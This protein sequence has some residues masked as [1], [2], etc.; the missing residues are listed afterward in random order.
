MSRCPRR[1]GPR[2]LS[3]SAMVAANGLL[4]ICVPAALF[5][6]YVALPLG[7][8]IV[9]IS[10]L[11]WAL[12]L[13]SLVAVYWTDP[14]F[15]PLNLDPPAV[16]SPPPQESSLPP[17]PMPPAAAALPPLPTEYPFVSAPIPPLSS[18]NLAL[19]SRTL[20]VKGISLQVKYCVSCASW[21]PPRTSHCS[22]CDRCVHGHDHHCPWTGNCIGYRN[23]RFFY[24]FLVSA[25]VLI[26]WVFGVSLAVLIENLEQPMSDPSTDSRLS[27]LG[28]NPVPILL[29]VYTFVFG[30]ALSSLL[31]YHTLL[32]ARNLSTHEEVRRKYVV[33]REE[34]GRSVTQNPFDSG[35]CFRNCYTVLFKRSDPDR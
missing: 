31:F 27:A 8:A 33:W 20:F 14:G 10:G 17:I 22:L 7:L 25:E 11:L 24:A 35:G 16:E 9:T 13:A 6:V 15:I 30:L 18:P 26:L 28:S 32:V 21:R 19:R 34:D 4:L 5:I 23:Y 12:A 29:L 2:R 1:K 3:D